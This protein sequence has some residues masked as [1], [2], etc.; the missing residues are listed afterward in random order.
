MSDEDVRRDVLPIPD[1]PYPGA[2]LYDAK[3]PD[4]KF[5]PIRPL[6]PPAGAPNV[7]VVLLDDVGFG[8]SSA[9]G[10]PV[11]T[12]TAERL[13]GEGLKYTRFH[14]TALCSPT[15]AAL[16]GGRNHHTVGMGA[17]TEF[18]T[19][20]PGYNT[21]R[22][23]TCSPL[24]EI[25]KLNGYATAH[26]GKCH[27]VPV[28]ETSPAG[29]FD[30]WP[31]PGNGFEYFYGFFGGETDQWYPTLHEG[32]T[33]VEPRS[34]P[35]EG[36][37]LT[38]D[39]T[40]KAIAWIGQQ[41]SLVPDKP[42]FMYFATG[43]THAPH[44][45]PKEWADKYTGLFDDGWDALRERTF[46]RQKELGVIPPDAELTERH[47]EI[48]AWEDMP[49]E[50]KPVL[51]RQME[52]YAGFLEH[53]DH[54]V[55][56]LVRRARTDGLLE[57][58]L[59]YYIIGDNGASAE[60]S[61]QGT[62]NELIT[63]Q[64]PRTRAR[65]AR[66]LQRA[67]R[68]DRRAGVDAALRGRLGARDVH[69]VSV[70]QADRVA[71]GRNTQR[72]DRALAGRDRGQGRAAPPVHARHR[73]RTDR[74]GGHRRPGADHGQRHHAAADGRHQHALQ[75]RRRR[76]PRAPRDPVLRDDRATAACTTRAGR[77]DQAPHAVA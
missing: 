53:T 23:N 62:F 27:E 60:G 46:A 55:G 69:P 70:D 31:S 42:F 22:P 34:T 20:A 10:G 15:R 64:R 67:A 2:V 3:D 47:E 13:A 36:Y 56:L 51:R 39:L 28:W 24:P 73:R 9:F 6:R 57:D 68:Q 19:S 41:K 18:A 32:I 40:E 1:R 43:A 74:P 37:H 12:P 63:P 35:E 38:P 66:V 54:H 59:I 25:L 65:D 16:I 44:H 21:L 49:E 5:P 30:R 7:L 45:V 17:I 71:L 77:G 26:I 4:A 61:P 8:A 52:N 76:R 50:L 33:R 72:H 58:T 48:P 11:S 29:P 14:T 75:L